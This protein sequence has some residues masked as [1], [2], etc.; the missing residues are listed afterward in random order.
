MNNPKFCIDYESQSGYAPDTEIVIQKH[1]RYAFI[2]MHSHEYIEIAYVRAG[3]GIHVLGDHTEH[4]GEGNIYVI[5][6][7]DSHMFKSY[8]Q[9]PFI[10]YNVIFRPTFFG[11]FFG[12]KTSLSELINHFLLRN[13][14]VGNFQYSLSTNIP[15][16]HT[17]FFNDLFDRMLT[18]YTEQRPGYEELLRLYTLEL[19]IHISRTAT[20]DDS[21][22]QLTETA[23]D[24][25]YKPLV[26][27]QENYNEHFSLETLSKLAFISP[28]YFSRLFRIHNGCTLTEYVQNLRIEHAC[29]MLKNT[30][31]SIAQIAENV[32]YSDIGY[33]NKLFKKVMKVSPSE[34]RRR[35][36]T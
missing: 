28:K 9:T 17:G 10:I 30:Q 6:I 24:I 12:E 14:R 36:N 4:C 13:F 8:E 2:D 25:F 16:N 33:F 21:Q 1:D 11:E 32:G 22:L 35:C 27:L 19:L 20:I 3:K 23:R 15:V 5:D 31:N 29:D 34:F 26:Y 18:E 7:G